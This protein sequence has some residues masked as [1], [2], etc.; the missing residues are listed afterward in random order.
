[1]NGHALLRRLASARPHRR[2]GLLGGSFDPPHAGHLHISLWAMKRF[3]LDA[4]WWVFSPHNP[5]KPLPPAPYAERLATAHRLTAHPRIHFCDLETPLNIR[6][7]IDLIRF[8][9]RRHLPTRF[10]WLMG[11]DSFATIHHWRDWREI[12]VRLPIGIVTR[13]SARFAALNARAGRRFASLRSNPLHTRQLGQNANLGWCIAIAPL[14]D[15]SSTEQRSKVLTAQ[16]HRTKPA[17]TARNAL[18]F[19]M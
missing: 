12:M 8:L 11:S 5:L 4:V 6:H 1:M 15:T 3:R 10:I 14:N 17:S 7:T 2:I 13:R 16:P 18:N 9:E 19:Q